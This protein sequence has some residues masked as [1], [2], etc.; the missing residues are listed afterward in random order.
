MPFIERGIYK[1]EHDNNV[2]FIKRG[3]Y[4]IFTKLFPMTVFVLNEL[5]SIILQYIFMI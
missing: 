5:A 3:I 1:N 2:P 4:L